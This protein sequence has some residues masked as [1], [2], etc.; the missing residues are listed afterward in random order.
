[1][2]YKTDDKC[3]AK[4]MKSVMLTELRRH[5]KGLASVGLVVSCA[6]L[7]FQYSQE[8]EVY[9]PVEIMVAHDVPDNGLPVFAQF[10]VT[11]TL[12]FTEPYL[13]KALNIPIYWPDDGE[14]L[15][16]DLKRNGKLVQRW[17]LE[18]GSEKSVQVRQLLI[19]PAL[20]LDGELEVV[21]DGQHIAHQDQARAPRIFIETADNNYG[22]GHYRIANNEKKGDV[23]MFFTAQRSRWQGLILEGKS[24][25]TALIDLALR[26]VFG[27][28]L[29]ACVPF[30]AAGMIRRP[31]RFPG[32]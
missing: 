13:V 29:V 20:L 25:P 16:V 4:E 14:W 11:Q 32:R 30:T 1:M 8:V 12:S 26:L 21:F 18:P 28:I 5:G 31:V 23:G 10:T 24:N 3:Y 22:G 17:R 27:F 7:S 2:W 19:E 15:Q 9:T 6:W